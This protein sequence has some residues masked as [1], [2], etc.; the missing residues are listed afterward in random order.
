MPS[1]AHT[2]PPIPRRP[3]PDPPP[4]PPTATSPTVVAYRLLPCATIRIATKTSREAASTA[5]QL[6]L[7]T[8][9]EKNVAG[10]EGQRGETARLE[11]GG[12][13]QRGEIARLER[14]GRGGGGPTRSMPAARS[15][16]VP[17]RAPRGGEG[18]RVAS[19]N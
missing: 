2:P 8:F 11:R 16:G 4:Q 10:E 1:L 17:V 15:P 19:S 7:S 14:E 9:D 18:T 6:N 3:P 13:G 12:R 5:F